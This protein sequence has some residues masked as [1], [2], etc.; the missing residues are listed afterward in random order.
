MAQASLRVRFEP[1]VALSRGAGRNRTVTVGPW[2]KLFGRLAGGR[3]G[4][5]GFLDAESRPNRDGATPC[6][7][8]SSVGFEPLRFSVD[9]ARCVSCRRVFVIHVAKSLGSV[10]KVKL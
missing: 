2:Q 10:L 8:C 3:A 6:P 5:G 9:F 7:N 1:V 4:F